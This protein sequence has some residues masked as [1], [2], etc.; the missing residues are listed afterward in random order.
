MIFKLFIFTF[1]SDFILPFIIIKNLYATA[2]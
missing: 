2:I 1:T